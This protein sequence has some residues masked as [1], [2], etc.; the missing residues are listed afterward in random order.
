M[1]VEDRVADFYQL[2]IMTSKVFRNS[3]PQGRQGGNILVQVS[4]TFF[5]LA[6]C[7]Y[8]F[9]KWALVLNFHSV[10]RWEEI[11]PTSNNSAWSPFENLFQ[12]VNS[13]NKVWRNKFKKK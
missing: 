11:W 7:C 10:E 4:S 12:I 5:D 13:Q 6:S 1:K 9:Q 2:L 3:R 8:D